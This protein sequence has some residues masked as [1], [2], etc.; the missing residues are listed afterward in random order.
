[1]LNLHI[2]HCS[3]CGRE[4]TDPQSVR[5]GIGPVCRAKT[6][7]DNNPAQHTDDVRDNLI[8]E[9]LKPNGLVL[10]RDEDGVWTNI[11]HV[12]IHHSPTGFEF[13]Y[14]G[15]GP[16][17]LALNVVEIVLHHLGHNGPRQDCYDGD[18]FELAWALHQDFKWRFIATAPRDGVRIPYDEICAYIRERMEVRL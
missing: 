14:G 18:C 8:N 2:S 5:L 12:I 1:M 17:D 9:P 3:V 13:G 4:L 7:M 15:S 6:T 16:A 11:P 10:R